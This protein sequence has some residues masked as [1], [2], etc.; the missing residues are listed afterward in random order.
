MRIAL[1]AV[2]AALALAGAADAATSL[3]YVA[4][5]DSV[6]AGYGLA[7]SRAP[8]ARAEARSYPS[9]VERQLERR[10]GRVAFVFLACSGA[11][12]ASTEPGPRALATQVDGALRAIGRRRSVV[13]ITIGINDLQWWNLPRVAELLRGDRAT[14][15][16]WVTGT[17]GE[18]R[19]ELRRQLRRLLGRP[20]TEIVVTGYFD[21]VNR[22]SPL[23]LLCSDP[24][25]CRGRVREAV[26]R[27]NRAIRASTSGLGPRVRVAGIAGSFIGHEAARPA[28]GSAPPGA[29]QTWIQADCLH[30][31]D[32]GAAAIARA[33]AAEAARLGL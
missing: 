9:R 12:A 15:D 32:A 16:A 20:R 13:S 31:N 22:G 23:Y 4:L 28:C 11:T 19:V 26:A 33:V 29:D 14:Y 8:C 18:V 30:P 2:L 5:G 24:G 10:H 6:A 1:A 7:S 21:P 3:T 27:L 25:R 17:V